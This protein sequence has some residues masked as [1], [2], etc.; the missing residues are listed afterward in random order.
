MEKSS[1][2]QNPRHC[3]SYFPKTETPFV[4]IEDILKKVTSQQFDLNTTYDLI[5]GFRVI[6]ELID[7]SHFCYVM[8][9][10]ALTWRGQE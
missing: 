4:E 9:W 3:P 1:N 2:L 8:L 6:M 10:P 5:K 7:S